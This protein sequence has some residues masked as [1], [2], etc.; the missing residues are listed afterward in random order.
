[1][2]LY[3]SIYYWIYYYFF[4]SLVICLLKILR[5]ILVFVLTLFLFSLN[6]K[7]SGG[8]KEVVIPVAPDVIQQE[9]VSVLIKLK[10]M[11]DDV[12]AEE[13]CTRSEYARW[14]IKINCLERNP[15]Y[16]ILSNPVI[17]GPVITFFDDVN[18]DNPDFWYIQSLAEAGIV[19]SKLSALTFTSTL[20]NGVVSGPKK[21]QLLPQ[22]F[23][24]RFD[25]LNWKALLEYSLPSKFDVEM[26][27][28]E[29]NILDITTDR[30]VSPHVLVDLMASDNSIT[31][32]T[33]GNIRRLQP[34]KP[35]TKAQ[36]AV[37]LISGRMAEAIQHEISRLEA[38]KMSR[39]HDEEEIRSELI[40]KGDIQ[41]F[42]EGE[43]EKEQERFLVVEKEL[44]VAL[45]SLEDEKKALNDSLI[46]YVKEKGELTCREKL[47]KCLKE[48]V[49]QMYDNLASERADL[50]SEQQN[51]ER[52][53][54]ELCA[55]Q[56]AVVEA[57]SI[58]EAEKEAIRI[59]SSFTLESNLWNGPGLAY[60]MMGLS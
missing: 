5:D 32:R 17:V 3:W 1:M 27:R 23:L 10:I 50:L 36:A 11:E 16:K 44:K 49:D 57:K 56:D 39:L 34:C 19:L 28:N 40:Q 37:V 29:V 47:Q 7:E 42:W 22:S 2:L 14:F 33:F 41:R 6:V 26:L 20:N 21:I 48:E 24:S 55:K 43:L 18:P 45:L 59:V 30:D 60:H 15:K 35:V 53:S 52:Y 4:S 38:E 46:D 54:T 31:R 13:L 9:A 25:L 12:I 8:R 51:L 58:L